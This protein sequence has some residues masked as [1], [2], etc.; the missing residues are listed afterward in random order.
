MHRLRGGQAVGRKPV[1]GPHV[2]M[3]RRI[4]TAAA[5]SDRAASP[6]GYGR[7]TGIGP[8][9]RAWMRADTIHAPLWHLDADCPYPGFVPPLV[10]VMRQ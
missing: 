5:C 2:R 9:R 6:S 4:R 8:L 1:D 7:V 3:Q 10:R